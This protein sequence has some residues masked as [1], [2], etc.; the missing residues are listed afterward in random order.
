MV[1]S[2]SVSLA[3]HQGKH[4]GHF[5]KTE[6]SV[7]QRDSQNR[8]GTVDEDFC[9]TCSAQRISGEKL[10]LETF[11]VYQFAPVFFRPLDP[12]MPGDNPGRL[13]YP[14]RAPPVSL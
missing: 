8:S 11:T 5:L 10:Q 3:L 7:T 4:G 2:Q 13:F 9:L 6:L 14:A 12:S 1:G